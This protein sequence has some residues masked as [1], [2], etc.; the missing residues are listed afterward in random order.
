[1]LKSTLLVIV[2]YVV[3]GAVAVLLGYGLRGQHPL[4]LLALADAAATA[5]IFLF[6]LAVNNSSMYDPYWS[7]A[8]VPI[9]LFWL[10]QPGGAG[11]AALRHVLV[12]ALLCL[13]AIR[14][15][16]NWASQWRGLG[17][18]DWRYR[19]LRA[20]T[21]RLYWPVSFLGLH[22]MPTVLVFLG[23]LALWP[24]LFSGAQPFNWLDVLA[25]VVTGGAITIEA[26]ADVQM[27][28]FR[29]AAR[30]SGEAEPPGL[31]R[32]SRHPNY[33][34]EVSFWWG[35]FLFAL[36]ADPASWWV[37]VGPV[38]ITALFLF[39]SIPLM[40]RHIL[41]RRPDYAKYQQR[42]SAFVPWWR[43]AEAADEILSPDVES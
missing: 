7:V 28:R 16:Y 26:T 14:L 12:C 21:G 20:Q 39:A 5:L 1:M 2:A 35:L 6:S 4:L 25:C 19:D 10:L 31:W 41:A 36:A 33:F 22:L 11:F 23:C 8:P 43:R 40:E 27:R 3:A 34:G 29:R 30:T 24:A 38:S 17:H 15:T 32:S 37:V 13:W 18:E 42:V 9:A